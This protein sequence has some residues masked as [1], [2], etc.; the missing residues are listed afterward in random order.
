MSFQ[1]AASRGYA[2]PVSL[3]RPKERTPKMK[4]KSLPVRWTGLAMEGIAVVL[5]ANSML[6]GSAY[7]GTS[8]DPATTISGLVSWL[9]QNSLNY[10]TAVVASN[11]PHTLFGT[12]SEVTYSKIPLKAG[13]GWVT[14]WL[15]TARN[16]KQYFDDRAWY[17]PGDTF[18]ISPFP[19]SPD[20]TDS[21]SLVTA[22]AGQVTISLKNGSVAFSSACMNGVL[23]GGPNPPSLGVAPVYTISFEAGTNPAPPK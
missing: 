8:C 19:F 11:R 10:V 7:A 21:I 22:P 13:T 2:L 18:H 3:E 4:T 15:V 12:A 9:N 14:G 20:S 1:S 23:Y 6:V 16:G 5:F 17:K